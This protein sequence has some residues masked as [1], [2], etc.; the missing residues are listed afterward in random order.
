MTKKPNLGEIPKIPN[1]NHP[2]GIIK[3]GN[4]SLPIFQTP[5]PPPPP[6]PKKIK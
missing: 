3:G 6:K 4:N 2:T 1:L 5:P